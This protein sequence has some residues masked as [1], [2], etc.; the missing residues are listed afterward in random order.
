MRRE[1][2][3]SATIRSRVRQHYETGGWDTVS[4]GLLR[5][6]ADWADLRSVIDDY[7]LRANARVAS[8]MPNRGA[9]FLDAGSGPLPHD[10][11]IDYSS[12]FNRRVCADLSHVA[13]VKARDTLGGRGLY[14]QADLA[15]LPFRDGIFDA[16]YCAHVLYH[17]ADADQATVIGEFDRCLGPD[18]LAVVIA[19]RPSR[20]LDWL[21]DPRERIRPLHP[22]HLISRI[23][24][25]RKFVRFVLR[26]GPVPELPPPEPEPLLYNH[27]RPSSWWS[28]LPTADRTRLVPYTA[29]DQRLTLRWISDDERG[30]R[31]LCWV[32]RMEERFPR[33][34]IRA[35]RYHVALIRGAAASSTPATINIRQRSSTPEA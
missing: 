16:A 6:Q 11:E 4:P 28:R 31:R 2:D 9:L 1:A 3:R 24:G 32:S 15:R 12:G 27:P 8:H 14:V 18:G 25:V 17:V 7:Y 34:M 5:D 33:S 13:L 22:R 30:A 29:L 23:P 19:K 10:Y 21:A 26:R 35:G 20:V